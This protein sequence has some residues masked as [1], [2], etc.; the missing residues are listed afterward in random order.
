[1]ECGHCHF[2]VRCTMPRKVSRSKGTSPFSPWNLAGATTRA[3][4]RG[5]LRDTIVLPT[6]SSSSALPTLGQSNM[7]VFLTAF[8]LLTLSA[9]YCCC[10]Q[11]LMNAPPPSLSTYPGRAPYRH[12]KHPGRLPEGSLSSFPQ[13]RNFNSS[14]ECLRKST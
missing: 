4:L 6:E 7:S 11:H 14:R 9:M 13:S 5:S 2:L 8:P 3:P 12:C 1:M 10:R